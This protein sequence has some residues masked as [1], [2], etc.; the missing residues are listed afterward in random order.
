MRF[1]RVEFYH[2]S[3]VGKI[4]N[5]IEHAGNIHQN[6]T[7]FAHTGVAIFA[8]GRDLDCLSNRMIGPF[9]IK[10]AARLAFARSGGIC[11][12]L[13]NARRCFRGCNFSRDRPQTFPNV[14]GKNPLAARIRMDAIRLI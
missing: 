3:F 8:F 11:H 5:D 6:R 1:A 7:Q 4:D 14:L 2:H 10:R 12:Q 9:E 13:W